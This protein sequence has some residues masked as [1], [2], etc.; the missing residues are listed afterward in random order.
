M[1]NHCCNDLIISGPK[2]EIKRFISLVDKP[3]AKDGEHFDFSGILPCPKVLQGLTSPTRIKTA[4]E[5]KDAWTLLCD[6]AA[7]AGEPKPDASVKKSL[8]ISQEHSDVLRKK[9]G[10]DN[11]Y[12]WQVRN[13]GCKWGAS[14]T[15]KWTIEAN[16]AGIFFITA[17]CPPT[18]F[19]VYASSKFSK[20]HFTHRYAESGLCFCGINE[21]SGG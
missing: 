13:W 14:D 10:H 1:P 3:K 4:Q 15:G 12:D 8:G 21:I 11:W 19:L 18:E 16:E 6:Q 5:L 20:L 2:S 7:L 17:W 9:F